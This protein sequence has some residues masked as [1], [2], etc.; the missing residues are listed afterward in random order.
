M[1]RHALIG[2]IHGVGLLVGIE[3]VWDRAEMMPAKEIAQ[4]VLYQ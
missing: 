2:G 1:F 4:V 3:F